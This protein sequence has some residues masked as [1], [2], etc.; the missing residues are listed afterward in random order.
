[1]M[2]RI[3]QGHAQDHEWSKFESNCYR[4]LATVILSGCLSARQLF[5]PR[6]TL[7]RQITPIRQLRRN[8]EFALDQLRP[9]ASQ[10]A[11]VQ[12]EL[13]RLE[14]LFASYQPDSRSEATH[15]RQFFTESTPGLALG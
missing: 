7:L 3:D 1:M 11:E 13:D 6:I 4:E 10:L 14:K 5:H 12:H 15:D 2:H 8:I 9:Q